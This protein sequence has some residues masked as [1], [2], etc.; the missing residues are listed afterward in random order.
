MRP[1]TTVLFAMALLAGSGLQANS[2]TIRIGS[3]AFTESRLLGE[4]MAQLIEAHTDLEV[5]RKLGLGGTT[6]VFEAL[7]EGDLDLY[8]DYTGT[9][10]SVVLKEEERVTDPL[11]VYLHVATEFDRR[12]QLTW[13]APF[14]FN[15]G[16]AMAMDRE[17]AEALGVRTLSDLKAHEEE[18]RVG[19]SHE[20]L[21]R[22]DGYPGLAEAYDLDI[23]DIRGIEHGLAYQAI[24]N[25][26]LD[27]IDTYTTDGKLL[28]YDLRLL[29]DDRA[30]FPPYDAAPIIRNAVLK[31][32][33]ELKPLLEQLAFA[34]DDDT[35]RELN[36]RIEAEGGGYARVARDFLRSRELLDGLEESP[37]DETSE[38]E[39]LFVYFWQRRSEIVSLTAEH[40][41]LTFRA[42]LLAI[43]LS[44]PLGI[45]LT[46]KP[47]LAPTILGVAGVIQTIPSLALL[48][49]MIPIPGFGLDARSAIAAL[50][51]YALLPILRN[52]YTGIREIDAQLIEAARGIG[53]KD[54]QVLLKVELPLATRT[55]MAGIRTATVISIG[56]ATLAA[57]IGA[58]GLG[59]PILTGLQLD[60]VRLILTGAI[61]AAM[62]ALGVDFLLGIAEQRL[63]PKG[64]EFAQDS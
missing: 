56:V 20:F 31:R 25:G 58:G 2:D 57:F 7:R 50:F 12:Y 46:R 23:P 64:L 27:L 8:P 5:E 36:F 16:Y 4:M 34:I 15:N 10:W 39:G 24:D 55:I 59:E 53:L 9:G 40:L 41:W 62:L 3:K 26:D 11:R 61:P 54:H 13:L 30:F 32:H 14:G 1:L 33:P 43:L 48:A 35:M 18:I 44:V 60:D 51:L 21:D 19:V 49:F 47:Q 42:V 38:R 29:E 17:K 6:L 22:L 28:R 37:Q 52:T 63:A 45:F